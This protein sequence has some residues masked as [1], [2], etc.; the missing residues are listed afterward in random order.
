M[1]KYLQAQL[2]IDAG[3]TIGEGPTWDG[4]SER[5]IWSDNAS[6]VIHEAKADG[7]GE[8]RETGRWNLEIP[9]T[10]PIPRFGAAIPRIQGGFVLAG[11]TK[12]LKMDAAGEVEPFAELDADESLVRFNDAKCDSL[13]RLWVGTLAT[14]WRPGGAAL[15]RV[16]PDGAILTMLT[17]VTASNGL[18]WSPDESTMYFI[19]SL[20][21]SID[22]FDFERVG[23]TISNRRTLASIKFGEGLPDGMT[24]DRGG[25]LWVAVAGGGQ[26]RRYSPQGEFLEVV[27]VS[28]P[29]STSCTFGGRDRADLFITTAALR[30]TERFIAQGVSAE[31]VDKS[32]A[33][34]G[35]GGVFICRPGAV[36]KAA[37]PFGG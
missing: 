3:D 20:T 13:G 10:A 7:R 24:V 17:N 26:V 29:I 23:G 30:L 35:A 4:A 12:I 6:G 2:A 8:W 11:G 1:E 22:A 9:M 21:R 28:A 16:D 34:P 32:H 33:V 14:D 18:D 27:R 31:V 37:N 15:Y 36:G 19:D 25:D 5:L